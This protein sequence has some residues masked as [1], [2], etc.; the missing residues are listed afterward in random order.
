MYTCRFASN[1]TISSLTW[2][3]WRQFMD[4]ESL[5]YRPEPKGFANMN[6]YQGRCKQCSK[7]TLIVEYSFFLASRSSYQ[8]QT[9]FE[10][11]RTC[12]YGQTLKT[13]VIL[14]T[15]CCACEFALDHSI[16]N[17]NWACQRLI[18]P[19]SWRAYS[20]H[21]SHLRWLA[22][23]ITLSEKDSLQSM[24]VPTRVVVIE[25]HS[26]FIFA[27]ECIA[28]LAR[29][30]SY[31][32][33]SAARYLQPWSSMW[34]SGMLFNLLLCRHQVN[35]LSLTR[36]RYTSINLCYW[37]VSSTKR[38]RFRLKIS[39]SFKHRLYDLDGHCQ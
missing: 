5:L 39:V 19:C 20:T 28:K 15:S 38:P 2:T 10:A 25:Q 17:L 7:L 24:A 6:A 18:K 13:Q 4:L 26:E 34:D 35:F 29:R 30:S 12:D 1:L 33:N 3:I 14:P 31:K 8:N 27:I 16:S 36:L 23:G 21:S 37:K 11:R 22:Q 9:C 32:I